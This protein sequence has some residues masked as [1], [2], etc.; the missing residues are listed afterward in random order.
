MNVTEEESKGRSG[1]YNYYYGEVTNV[2]NL[3]LTEEQVAVLSS[4][5]NI[6]DTVNSI[7][8]PNV[9]NEHDE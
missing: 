9:K 1:I 8:N 2:I 3:R 7:I 6:A 4:G 5:N